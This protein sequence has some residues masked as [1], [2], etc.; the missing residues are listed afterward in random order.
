MIRVNLRSPCDFS[1]GFEDDFAALVEVAR[2]ASSRT[3]PAVMNAER[4]AVGIGTPTLLIAVAP[5]G[6]AA[7]E[8][9]A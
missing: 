3:S 6:G 7:S 9:G 4:Q 1:R 2:D 8:A 5:G